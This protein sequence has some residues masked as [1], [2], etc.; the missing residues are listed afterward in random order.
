MNDLIKNT[1]MNTVTLDFT[2]GDMADISLFTGRKNGRKAKQYFNV[3]NGDRFIFIANDY[4]V[5]TSSYFLGLVGEELTT[6]LKKLNNINDLLLRV[7]FTQ[8]NEVSQNECVRAIKR[9]LSE[10]ELLL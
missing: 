6:L 2:S 9:G 1:H 4:Q 7:D 3:R 8:L 5:I 10:N